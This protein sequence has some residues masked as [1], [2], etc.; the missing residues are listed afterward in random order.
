MAAG[1]FSRIIKDLINPKPPKPPYSHVVQIG[2]PAL[3][4]KA[5]TVEPKELGSE[6]I[7]QVIKTLV[8]TMRRYK[9]SGLAAPQIGVPVRIIAVEITKNHVR[10][11]APAVVKAREM[12][13]TP[14]RVFVNPELT[15]ED[16]TT[17]QSP[18]GCASLRALTGIVERYR[19]VTVSGVSPDGERTEW[20]ADG[21]A[22]RA[23]QHEMD[24][25]A[26][27]MYVDRCDP[28]TLEHQHW[29]LINA[30]A[31]RFLQ[32]FDGFRNR[33]WGLFL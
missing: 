30:R 13:V 16:F 33:Q 2:D 18:E 10:A 29:A 17:I 20:R 31:G 32:H 6:H 24:H 22:A 14:L 28:R 9:C 1:R 26:G 7:Q 27:L 25:L 3:R 8:K 5:L 12:R 15:V 4:A 23:V 21:W 11:H 19:S